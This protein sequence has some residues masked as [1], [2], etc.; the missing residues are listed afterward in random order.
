M[1]FAREHTIMK[2]KEVRL[3]YF[4]GSDGF[5]SSFISTPRK[6]NKRIKVKT[7]KPKR[8]G[9]TAKAVFECKATLKEI[10]NL[11]KAQNDSRSYFLDK[12]L[13]L[14]EEESKSAQDF[15]RQ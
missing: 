15:Q 12:F 6:K 13:Q 5:F 8:M 7:V 2:H 14:Y 3:T 11:T 9:D 10:T 1:F 4:L